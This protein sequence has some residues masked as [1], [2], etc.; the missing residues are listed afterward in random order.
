MIYKLGELFCGAGGLAYGAVN[1]DI[2]TDSKIVH[3]W[4]VDS[5]K[6]AC[7]TYRHNICKDDNAE[8]VICADVRSLNLDNLP[9]IDA[10]AFGFPCN[11]FSAI[12]RRKG[13]DGKFG[14]LY[15]YG[16]N[17]LE[18]FQ[19]QF[20]FAE[21]VA[22]LINIDKG[23]AYKQILSD[24]QSAGYKVFPHLYKFE[25]Y[26]I[27]QTRHR[28]IFI[29]IRKDLPFEFKPPSTIPFKNADISVKTALTKPP[30][31]KNAFNHELPAHS[32]KTIE[33]LKYIKPGRTAFNTD[34][35]EH[36]RLKPKK[37]FYHTKYLRLEPNK[38]CKT[39]CAS[40]GNP[41]YH[42]EENRTLTN[43]ERARVQSFPDDFKFFGSREKVQSQIGMAV[44]CRGAKIIF[45]SILKTF[46]GIDYDSVPCK[47][48]KYMR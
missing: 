30:I 36:L 10:F 19:P 44:P 29:G 9:A 8:S 12:G 6:D 2:G 7:Q 32:P 38:P 40:S 18:R 4:A 5:N 24:M 25:E 26:G 15:K 31:N 14:S 37:S 45:E 41:F 43:R 39:I 47:I 22:N 1:A 33:Q 16:I 34:L 46:D 28:I 23:N 11:D 48:F 17:V 27:P 13:F 20:F 3:E 42:Y 21:N 35:P